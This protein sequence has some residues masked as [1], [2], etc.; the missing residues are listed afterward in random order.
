MDRDHL[1]P[2]ESD[3]LSV[4]I[5][6]WAV[7][8]STPTEAGHFPAICE[9]ERAATGQRDPQNFAVVVVSYRQ[10]IESLIGSVLR[11]V[12]FPLDD[13]PGTDGRALGED[14]SVPTVL[15]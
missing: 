3:K 8:A 1:T 4:Y 9:A 14:R 5:H 7:A 11:L 2:S 12:G 6:L 15:T 13:D 10:S